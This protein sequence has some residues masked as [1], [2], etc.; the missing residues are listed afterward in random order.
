MRLE[1]LDFI[2]WMDP[3]NR[4]L[5]E[6]LQPCIYRPEAMIMKSQGADYG[7]QL[8]WQTS[9]GRCAEFIRRGPGAIV[10]LPPSGPSLT[11]GSPGTS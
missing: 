5:R 11:W 9:S 7:I 4:P 3:M 6:D 10:D 1:G 2:L 8:S